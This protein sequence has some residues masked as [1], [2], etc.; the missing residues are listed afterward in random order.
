VV[1]L[2][3]A[4]A[5]AMVK[6][7]E[8]GLN[9]VDALAGDSRLTGYAYLPA[10]RADLLRRLGRVAE[11]AEANE[12]A[13]ALATNASERRFLAQRRSEMCDAGA[14]APEANYAA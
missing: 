1:A 5:V 3:R 10:A 2:N 14:R 11:A 4:V 12:E 7:P 8:A 6:G 13:L 9:A